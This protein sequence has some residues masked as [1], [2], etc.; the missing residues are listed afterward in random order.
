MKLT[1][2]LTFYW[3]FSYHVMGRNYLHNTSPLTS[4]VSRSYSFFWHSLNIRFHLSQA[5]TSSQFLDSAKITDKFTLN[6]EYYFQ[7]T[8]FFKCRSH[9]GA[10]AVV[11]CLLLI[12][13][14][15]LPEDNTT[16]T[17]F[18]WLKICD[19]ILLAVLDEVLILPVQ[20]PGSSNLLHSG[21]HFQCFG[22]VNR[23]RPML[24]RHTGI[25]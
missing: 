11:S 23:T 18:T 12:F 4:V 13:I 17:K 24:E 7:W 3:L 6:E 14:R 1:W 10:M 5:N 22:T 16:A 19:E 8:I 21:R 2:I 20:V 25:A 15:L 9:D